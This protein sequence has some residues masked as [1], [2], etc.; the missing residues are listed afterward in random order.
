MQKIYLGIL[1]F[2]LLN[3]FSTASAQMRITEF[4]YNGSEFVEFSNIGAT[5]INMNGW[6][7]DDNS[8]TAG[9]FS[10]SAYGMVRAG[11]SVILSETTAA[12]FRT[13][14]NLC[15][16]IKVIGS[17]TQNLGRSDEINL[18]D[19][20]GAL[21]DRLTYN[22][23]GTTPQGGPRTDVNSAWVPQSALGNNTHIN[24]VLSAAG[25]TENSF[26]ATSGGFIA[27]P[28][29]SSRTIVPYNP[30]APGLMRITEFQ[31]NGSEFV[32]LTNL[33]GLAVDMT[34]WSFDDNT[35]TA[36]SF[37]L[38]D[39]G[40]VKGGESVIISETT[41]AAFRTLW[42]LCDGIK[43][44]GGNSQN[45]GRSDEINIY[46]NTGTLID[47][48]TYNDQGTAPQGGPRTDVNSAWVPQAALGNNTHNACILSAVNDAEGS[49]ASSSGGFVASPGK[50][51]RATVSFD[52]CSGQGSGLPTIQ[53]DTASTS[54]L[55]DAGTTTAPLSPFAVSAVI[56][57]A[58]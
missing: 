29:K 51:A 56:N 35:R 41:A 7:F 31:Y 6:S 1:S 15:D 3:L 54:N 14:W 11:E 27:S 9:A 22:D 49:Y 53:V 36:G 45:L 21:V 39:F 10:L 30:C 28:G 34:G 40:S 38:S 8:R 20:S 23:Q 12:D 25:D 18:Y 5:A 37:S 26:A 4:Q 32:E 52:P 55:V 58:T 48:L 33:G 44:I 2:F 42:N 50:S 57:D 24:W 17:N 43:V 46:D 19:N 13:L 16:N 47:R